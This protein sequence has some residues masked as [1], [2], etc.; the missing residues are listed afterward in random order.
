MATKNSP[1][2]GWGCFVLLLI[3]PLRRLR[4]WR[5]YFRTCG[6]GRRRG[7]TSCALRCGF[8][9]LPSFGL[10]HGFHARTRR[11]VGGRTFRCVRRPDSGIRLSGAGAFRTGWSDRSIS[12][13]RAL[14]G[15]SLRTLSSLDVLAGISRER[16]CLLGHDI[17]GQG[18]AACYR[19][20]ED[21]GIS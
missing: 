6:C 20:R 10:R 16:W 8:G 3:V 7:R 19:D 11:P 5:G 14:L 1:S 4:R 15:L 18:K 13:G 21:C 2:R 17:G 9:F 12:P